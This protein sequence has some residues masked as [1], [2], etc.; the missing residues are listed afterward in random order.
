MEPAGRTG[1]PHPPFCQKGIPC[2]ARGME[3]VKVARY[4]LW[5]AETAQNRRKEPNRCSGC[6]LTGFLAVWKDMPKGSTLSLK[7][8]VIATKE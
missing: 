5:I 3:P 6:S 2:F 1:N 4:A 8:K 7:G